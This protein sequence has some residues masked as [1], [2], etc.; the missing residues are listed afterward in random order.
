MTLHPYA[1]LDQD[2]DQVKLSCNVCNCVGFNLRICYL[3]Y[4]EFT[5]E[6]KYIWKGQAPLPANSGL[7]VS[8]EFDP[9]TVKLQDDIK[10][11]VS[12]AAPPTGQATSPGATPPTGQATSP[13]VVSLTGGPMSPEAVLPTRQATSLGAASP[14]GQTM[15][16]GA[17]PP[18]GQATPSGNTSPPGIMV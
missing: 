8:M 11:E 17:A 1:V 13:G 4:K 3:Q 16:P 7:K 9:T 12:G 5:D 15:S 14:T 10:V 18:T 6:I 2:P